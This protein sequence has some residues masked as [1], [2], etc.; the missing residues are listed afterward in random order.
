MWGEMTR[1]GLSLV[2]RPSHLTFFQGLFRRS[3]AVQC[4]A[5]V[6]S[7]DWR[8]VEFR[9]DVHRK[10]TSFPEELGWTPGVWAGFERPVKLLV[11]TVQYL[12]CVL[13]AAGQTANILT[14]IRRK[15]PD[16]LS[17]LGRPAAN[18]AAIL[19]GCT[20]FD[21]GRSLASAIL[22]GRGVVDHGSI[23]A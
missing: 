10:T 8:A 12:V 5:G 7:D 13:S 4:V 3:V 19:A 1:V 18:L 23:Q 20:V 16:I 21:P 9:S 22:A 2:G 11:G 14:D 15:A 6:S 17:E